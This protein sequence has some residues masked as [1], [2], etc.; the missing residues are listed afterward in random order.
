[1]LNTSVAVCVVRDDKHFAKLLVNGFTPNVKSNPGVGDK[2]KIVAFASYGDNGT[3]LFEGEFSKIMKIDDDENLY[4]SLSPAASPGKV[5]TMLKK[6]EYFF[7]SFLYFFQR[8]KT[9]T[10]QKL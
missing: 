4:G 9:E 10:T 2:I 5:S 3:L 1:M 8:F 6:L 7:Y